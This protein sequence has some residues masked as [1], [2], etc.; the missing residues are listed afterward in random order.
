MTGS[1]TSQP[2]TFEWSHSTEQE[3]A[4]FANAYTTKTDSLSLATTG[5]N[6]STTT[7][8]L[9]EGVTLDPYLPDN[10]PSQPT[11][12]DIHRTN[13]QLARTIN[14]QSE[15]AQLID[16][17]NKRITPAYLIR[18]TASDGKRSFHLIHTDKK[19]DEKWGY[20]YKEATGSIGCQ[21][22]RYRTEYIL[23]RTD[24]DGYQV[25]IDDQDGD[26]KITFKTTGERTHPEERPD[27]QY[28]PRYVDEFSFKS[29][30]PASEEDI[31]GGGYWRSP[32]H[33]WRIGDEVL[34]GDLTLEYASSF[35]R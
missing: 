6:D 21:L 5:E 23:N 8:G 24:L 4:L 34:S 30:G 32:E 9:K 20:M 25:S 26:G 33:G 3:T 18:R 14:D 10:S 29:K 16:N 12:D 28:M 22:D 11:W 7:H 1:N 19:S 17:D 31:K 35:R 15:T 27:R 2:P 13:E